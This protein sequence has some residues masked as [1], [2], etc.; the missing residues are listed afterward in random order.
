MKIL[1]CK[2]I[3]IFL[4]F[5]SELSDIVNSSFNLGEPILDFKVVRKISRSLPKIFSPKVIAI[6]KNKD[7]DLMRIDEIIGFIQTYEMTLPN[8]QKPKDSTFK[9]SKN[10]E[11]DIKMPYNITRDE[12]KKIMKHTRKFN[13]NQES[14]KG[15]RPDKSSKENDRSISKGRKIE[16]LTVVV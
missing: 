7:I 12:L 5:Y 10:E 4:P 16:C 1:G 15:K 11:K 9:T 6:E 3:K 14:G 13:K 2:K 8:S